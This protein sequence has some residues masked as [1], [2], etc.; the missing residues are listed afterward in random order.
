MFV[1][2]TRTERRCDWTL[3]S[4]AIWVRL[5]FLHMIT[6]TTGLITDT[7]GL[8]TNATRTRVLASTRR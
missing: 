8:I 5:M 4:N 6:D 2:W 3:T 7:T 1:S